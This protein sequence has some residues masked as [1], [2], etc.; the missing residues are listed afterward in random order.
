MQLSQKVKKSLGNRAII[1]D[2]ASLN[3]R[4]K[5]FSNRKTAREAVELELLKSLETI[6]LEERR[7]ADVKTVR[8][9]KVDNKKQEELLTLQWMHDNPDEVIHMIDLETR[10][11]RLR[12]AMVTEIDA[13]R[14]LDEARTL[15]L[16][17]EPEA[18]A[19]AEAVNVEARALS[20]A[21]ASADEAASVAADAVDAANAA[22]AASHLATAAYNNTAGR[23]AN[24]R[25]RAR[26]ASAVAN[27]ITAAADRTLAGARA[28]VLR[29]NATAAAAVI[30][31]RTARSAA[32]E[33][34]ARDRAVSDRVTEANDNVVAA[35]R[36]IASSTKKKGPGRPTRAEAAARS[37]YLSALTAR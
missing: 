25:G 12:P 8:Q 14:V 24:V 6:F 2:E 10:Q 17:T 18:F 35:A 37:A 29:A 30:R 28:A 5:E 27:G 7:P 15:R 36:A 20:A 3:H 16:E 11:Q 1:T 13:R 4:E 31:A 33:A 19:A 21:N 23:N 32:E 26:T 22:L 9:A 34:Y